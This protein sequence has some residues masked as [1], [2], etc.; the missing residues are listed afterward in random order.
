MNRSALRY[1]LYKYSIEKNLTPAQRDVVLSESFFSKVGAFLGLGGQVGGALANAFKNSEVQTITKSMK[2]DFQDLK[3]I[4]SKLDNG[5][6]VVIGLLKSLLNDVGFKPENIV[7]AD[8]SKLSG[9]ASGQGA[10][11]GSGPITTATIDKNPA[12]ATNLVAAL[13]DKKPEEVAS[14]IE[15]KKPNAATVSK[16]I[17]T[18][19]SGK[20]GVE[21]DKATKIVKALMDTGHLVFEGRRPVMYTPDPV[22]ERWQTLAGVDLVLERSKGNAKK[23]KNMAA[24][25]TGGK[26]APGAT[27]PTAPPA[28]TPAPA[29][30]ETSGTTEK[31]QASGTPAASAEK[32]GA[33]TKDKSGDKK[34]DQNLETKKKEFEKPFKDIRGKVKEEEASDEEIIKVFDA[35]ISAGGEGKG[36]EVK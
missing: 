22:M 36:P 12:A 7:N 33:E 16:T 31:P 17:A 34:P 2:K 15:A 29:A 19:I 5:D 13:T 32:T 21:V 1:K 20:V 35:I 10:S 30:K 27:S 9:K 8:L 4:A 25:N 26:P 23:Q 18:A 3:N 11:Q 28:A 14:A 24:K 6:Q